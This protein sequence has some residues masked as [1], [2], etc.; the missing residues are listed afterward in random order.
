MSNRPSNWLASV[1]CDTSVTL[2]TLTQLMVSVDVKLSFSAMSS[3]KIC[4]I[5]APGSALFSQETTPGSFTLISCATGGHLRSPATVYRV[6]AQRNKRVSPFQSWDP[7]ICFIH[8]SSAMNEPQ[9]DPSTDT[10]SVIQKIHSVLAKHDTKTIEEWDEFVMKI[11]PEPPNNP[12]FNR[13]DWVSPTFDVDTFI[14]KRK[15]IPLETLRNL[16]SSYLQQVK[17]VSISIIKQDFMD[18]IH[19]INSLDAL[20][21][22]L[23]RILSPLQTVQS[24]I[25]TV[26]N[27]MASIVQEVHNKQQR[28]IQVNRMKKD[29][30]RLIQLSQLLDD[31]QAA[32]EKYKKGQC[33]FPELTRERLQFERP[34]IESKLS[35]VSQPSKFHSQLKQ[36]V[37]DLLRI[38]I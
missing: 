9:Q 20:E 1:K 12:C 21:Q 15:E 34:Y 10:S 27:Q 3:L 13:N 23:K 19:M 31:H 17:K 4:Q 33:K 2:I 11:L 30:D 22:S 24:E 7:R 16:L 36:R 25:T 28:L 35:M 6:S 5:L 14:E 18:L 38:P 8:P 26:H 32:L 29:L 37:R